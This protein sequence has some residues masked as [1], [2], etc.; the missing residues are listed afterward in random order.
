MPLELFRRG[1][2]VR[3]T[4]VPEPFSIAMAE[5][6]A[7]RRWG[8]RLATTDSRQQGLRVT[9]VR[10]K[11]PAAEIG[12]APGDR[13]LNINGMDLHTSE[14]FTRAVSNAYMDNAVMLVVVR[15]GRAYHV[16][17]RL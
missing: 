17:L 11:S 14:N 13:L 2:L 4:L 15:N 12:I 3:L 5:R 7:L 1:E 16:P 6:V 8:I 10:A 9:E